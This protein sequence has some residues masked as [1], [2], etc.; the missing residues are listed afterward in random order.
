MK[1]KENTRTTSH[2]ELQVTGLNLYQLLL[3][4]GYDIPDNYEMIIRVPGGGDWSNM[5]LDIDKTNPIK[6]SWT[7]ITDD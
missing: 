3:D 2:K 4:A 5:D 7:E 1:I 6:V